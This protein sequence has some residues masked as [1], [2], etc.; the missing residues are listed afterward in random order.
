MVSRP[1]D[2]LAETRTVRNP[3]VPSQNGSAPRRNVRDTVGAG[4]CKH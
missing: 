2:G 3:W 1:C 4:F